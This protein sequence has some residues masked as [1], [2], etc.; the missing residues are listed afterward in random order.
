LVQQLQLG[1]LVISVETAQRQAEERGHT[2]L[3]EMRI[4]TVSLFCLLLASHFFFIIGVPCVSIYF[5]MVHL[6]QYTINEQTDV[7]FL[8]DLSLTKHSDCCN[9]DVE[10]ILRLA[11]LNIKKVG[12]LL[13]AWQVL[14]I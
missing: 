2:L 3:D 9:G 6:D 12:S 10:F 7:Y 14:A 8:P 5:L 13:T 1:D 11:E 4:L